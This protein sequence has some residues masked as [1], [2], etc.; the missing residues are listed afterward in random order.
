M[1]KPPC[2][3][4][5]SIPGVAK[6]LHQ[7]RSAWHGRSLGGSTSVG[8]AGKD[9]FRRMCCLGRGFFFRLHHY[10][11]A[12]YLED[13]GILQWNLDVGSLS[14]SGKTL[15]F[16]YTR[17][18]KG[19]GG[20][21]AGSR[22]SL[23]SLR[24][25]LWALSIATCFFRRERH[26]PKWW[27]WWWW[28]QV[29]R[30]G[31]FCNLSCINLC[32]TAILSRLELGAK[33][34]PAWFGSRVCLHSNSNWQRSFV[35]TPITLFG[36]FFAVLLSWRWKHQLS[37]GTGWIE[38]W[39]LQYRNRSTLKPE[40]YLA[41]VET[42]QPGQDYKFQVASTGRSWRK[43]QWRWKEENLG[44]YRW[45]WWKRLQGPA[46]Q[47]AKQLGIETLT[48]EDGVKR[49]LAALETELLPLREA[50]CNGTLQRWPDSPRSH[51][52]PAWWEHEAAICWGEEAWWT[53]LREL[54]DT[55]QVSE[56]ILGETDFGTGRITAIGG[57]DGE[58]GLQEWPQQEGPVPST[59]RPIWTDTRSR[60][61]IKRLPRIWKIR[62]KRILE[63]WVQE[64]RYELHGRRRAGLSRSTWSKWGCRHRLSD[65]RVA[66]RGRVWR[67]LWRRVG[68]RAFYCGGDSSLLVRRTRH[69]GANM[70]P[71]RLGHGDWCRGGRA[72]GL[73]HKRPGTPKRI[74]CASIFV[75]SAVYGDEHHG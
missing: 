32:G 67:L 46:L 27:W 18:L 26:S 8:G 33:Q 54:D 25:S 24:P 2:M 10:L 28:W 51:E 7:I 56:A 16:A 43:D 29:W 34:V 12:R 58:D 14:G 50:S 57:P 31:C 35:L 55:L 11:W 59:Q 21:F 22:V 4:P 60:E 69:L 40:L 45:G 1:G 53:Q 42:Q 73:L 36:T 38:V 20:G 30:H 75:I 19:T 52:P 65:W 6:P 66:W 17:F 68:P 39:K 15:T 3:E 74:E 9:A 47:V 64:L 13:G 63:P 5:S 37:H 48:Q 41:M 44:H 61:D 49:L 23:C 70:Q 72:D 62:R 71:R